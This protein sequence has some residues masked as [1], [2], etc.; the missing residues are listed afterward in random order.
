M[1]K[2]MEI[3]EIRLVCVDDFDGNDDT[4]CHA[5]IWY[6]VI[7]KTSDE[8]YPDEQVSTL[9]RSRYEEDAQEFY[10]RRTRLDVT[11]FTCAD[12]CNREYADDYSKK[13]Y[14]DDVVFCFYDGIKRCGNCA[15]QF[16][17]KRGVK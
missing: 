13:K 1:N 6:K 12:C 7:Q 9:Y 16:F 10:K 4:G 17:N 3:G 5:D 11:E 14:G 8:G 2:A 15:C